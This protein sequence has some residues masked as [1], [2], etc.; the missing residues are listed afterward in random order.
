MFEK[1]KQWYIQGLWT[2]AMVNNAVLKTRITTAQA[3]EILLTQL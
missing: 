1:I 2:A 3:Q